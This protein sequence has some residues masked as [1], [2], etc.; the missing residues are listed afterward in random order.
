MIENDVK[1]SCVLMQTFTQWTCS[2]INNFTRTVEGLEARAPDVVDFIS[3]IY[4]VIC[5]Q[6]WSREAFDCVPFCLKARRQRL[7]HERSERGRSRVYSSVAECF[8]LP[9]KFMM[10]ANK[11]AQFF[12]QEA[13]QSKTNKTTFNLAT[14]QTIIY[15]KELIAR[16]RFSLFSQFLLDRGHV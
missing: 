8:S 6:L 11:C 9:L 12:L 14:K 2:S 15:I 4:M 16:F 5:G 10:Q 1:K 3:I 7:E 13:C